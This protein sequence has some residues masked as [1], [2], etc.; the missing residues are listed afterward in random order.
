[1]KATLKSPQGRVT[2]HFSPWTTDMNLLDANREPNNVITGVKVSHF[3]GKALQMEKVLG[4]SRGRALWTSLIAKGYKR[5]SNVDYREH[6]AEEMTKAR[7]HYRLA[8]NKGLRHTTA[9]KYAFSVIDGA[10]FDGDRVGCP[11]L[12]LS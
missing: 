12:T 6:S 4:L 5:N 7:P 9:W 11:E 2:W 8:V 10:S 3:I 1:M